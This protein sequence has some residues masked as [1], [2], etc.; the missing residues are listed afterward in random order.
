MKTMG[1][2]KIVLSGMFIALV[3]VS[4]FINIPY[5]GAAGGLM[6]LGTLMLFIISLKFGKTYGALAGGVGMGI[7]DVLGGWMAWAPV[8]FIVRFLMGF[9]VGWIAQDKNGQGKNIYKNVLAIVAGSLVFLAGY[10][11]YEAVFLTTFEA[12]LVSIPGNLAQIGVGLFSLLI[13][14]YIPDIKKIV[15]SER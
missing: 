7:F 2:Q 5:P 8:T 10:Y 13:I 12:A 6:H 1:T 4:T 14:L 3:T 15:N 9:V 11:L